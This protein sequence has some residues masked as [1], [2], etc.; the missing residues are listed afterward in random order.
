M[1]KKLIIL[2]SGKIPNNIFV[3]F[4]SKRINKINKVKKTS[5]VQ[6]NIAFEIINDQLFFGLNAVL[7]EDLMA[8]ESRNIV[9]SGLVVRSVNAAFGFSIT[10]ELKR[11]FILNWLVMRPW[12]SSYGELVKQVIFRASSLKTPIKDFKDIYK[13][14]IYWMELRN[15]DL[16]KRVDEFK[17]EG[18]V[19]GDLIIDTY[20]RYKPSPRFNVH[21][22]F[23]VRLIWQAIRDI[24]NVRLSFK[25]NKPKLYIT[26]YSTYIEH[27][28]PVRVAI[29]QNIPV[30]SFGNVIQFG[31]QLTSNH[32][33]HT[34]NARF[35]KKIIEKLP[36]HE[37]NVMLNEAESMLRFRMSGGIDI[38]TSYMKQSAYKE[39]G[40]HKIDPDYLKSLNGSVVIF[41]HDFY[42]SPHVFDDLIFIDFWEWLTKTIE[43]LKREN[44]NFFI[45]PHPNQVDLKDHAYVD[46]NKKYSELKWLNSA[47]NNKILVEAG[48]ACGVTV[49][50]TVAHE[51][52]YLGVHSI[53]AALH[54][55]HTFSFCRQAKTIKEYE[56]LLVNCRTNYQSKEILKREALEFFIAHNSLYDDVNRELSK[57]YMGYC[58]LAAKARSFLEC[59]CA[60]DALMKLRDTP[61]YKKLISEISMLINMEC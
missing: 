47:Y 58:V 36:E 45:K 5:A 11:N 27:G 14:L 59:E 17:I 44:I 23:V 4:V 34:P 19:C 60:M 46:L 21:D 35:Y 49:Y 55:H 32:Y 42:D 41:L 25:I 48:I 53:G 33:K 61:G 10:S 22:I 26:S 24:N 1:I 9:A 31:L 15:I 8:D 6:K 37:L 38:A 56:N 20:L 7:L 28:I 54:V 3:Y 57:S 43:I 52:A 12:V 29:E 18:V 40:I 39:Q 51:L 50:G 16:N 2:I 30:L 13:A